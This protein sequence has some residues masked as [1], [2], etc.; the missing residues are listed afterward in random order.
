MAGSATGILD[1]VAAVRAGD[2]RVAHLPAGSFT[3][4]VDCRG[5]P[6][7]PGPLT[8]R[9]VTPARIVVFDPARLAALIE[10]DGQAAAAWQALARLGAIGRDLGAPAGGRLPGPDSQLGGGRLP[11]PDSQA[12]VRLA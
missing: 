2:G 12:A 6:A 4:S 5:P 7:A 1:G 9:L 3:G 8:V 11:G 10:A